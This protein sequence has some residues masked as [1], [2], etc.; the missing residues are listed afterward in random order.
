M[1]TQADVHQLCLAVHVRNNLAECQQIVGNCGNAIITAIDELD[2]DPKFTALHWAACEN[3]AAILDWFLSQR[4]NCNAPNSTNETAMLRAAFHGSTACAK[5]LLAHGAD[6]AI[7][8]EVIL[9]SYAY[10]SI[11][12]SY[13]VFCFCLS[14]LPLTSL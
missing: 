8:D 3:H 11:W 4:I 5:L 10:L 2:T 1:F 7:K 12:G 14:L 13:L 6:I 9:C